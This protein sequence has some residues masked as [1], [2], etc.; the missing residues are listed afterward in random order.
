MNDSDCIALL[1]WAL[2]RL[3]L[4][5][6]GY[7]KVRRQVCKRIDR[8]IR[9][10]GLDGI[11]AYRER[12]ETDPSEWSVLDGFARI[13][14]SR[15]FRE[16]DAFAFLCDEA[17]VELG[18]SAAPRPVRIWS[19]GCAGGE[20]PYTLAIAAAVHGIDVRITATD[21]DSHQLRRAREARYSAGSL[22][23]LPP[24]WRERAF[25][26]LN[27]EW[28]LRSELRAP[29]ELVQQDIREHM[30]DGPFHM[31][32]CR[33]LAFMYFDLPLQRRIATCLLERTES[34]GLLVLGKREAWPSGVRGVTEVRSGLRIYR[35]VDATEPG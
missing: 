18:R 5:W 26:P 24:T 16:R 12:L 25:E 1:Q 23:D 27:D 29:V 4:R 6:P 17:L 22:K 7:R 20:E 19:A 15:F 2:P 14:I 3:H 34:G 11:E 10:L 32:L 21:A 8:R 33:Y 13:T 31:V 35:K 9:S 28:V 30:P